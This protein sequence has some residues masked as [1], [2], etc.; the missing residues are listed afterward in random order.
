MNSTIDSSLIKNELNRLRESQP[1]MNQAKASLFNLII[2]VHDPRRLEYFKK[3]VDMILEKFPCRIIFI[4]RDPSTKESTL[5]VSSLL[6]SQGISDQLS[7]KAS[8][9]GLDRVPF[10]IY[11][12]LF[13][14]LP[15][16]L[17]W[18]P[19]L[20]ADTA[21]L[22]QIK[23][24]ATRIIID[25]E[26]TDNLQN[27]CASILKQLAASSREIVDMNWFRIAGWKS[28]ISRAFDS[29]DR[30]ELL[31]KASLVKIA[32]NQLK[33]KDSSQ[34]I[35]QAFYLQAWLASCLGWKFIKI[36]SDGKNSLLLYENSFPIEVHLE[37]QNRPDLP[38]EEVIEVQ[39]SDPKNYDC[40]FFRK[41]N[42]EI[43]VKASNQYQCLLPFT[44][45]LP[46]L[47]SG[48]SFMQE[49]FYQKISMQY[50]EV[51]QMI[52][53]INPKGC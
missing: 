11:P 9:E 50:P 48:R 16:Y 19:D 24:L 4:Q 18:S 27:F 3:V 39:I 7:I 45:L 49:V 37:P 43:V 36:E 10:L 5:V 46:S 2:Y 12:H 31:K 52:S 53:S 51:L 47:Q 1:E 41:S 13:P 6:G 26:D 21:I 33:E 34:V 42:N 23:N 29:K 17:F 25:S 40:T 44:L 20:T 38:N 28:I 32:Y 22:P 35:T 8:G 15:I 14:E 30:I